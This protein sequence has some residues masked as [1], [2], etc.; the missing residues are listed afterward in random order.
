M[1]VERPHA[2]RPSSDLVWDGGLHATAF[3][4]DGA[5]LTAGADVGWTPELLMATAAGT[6]LMTLVLRLASEAGIEILGY[7]S[8]QRLQ[9]PSENS[10]PA[11]LVSPCISVRS[12]PAADVI[13]SLVA[14]AI[15]MARESGTL[16]RHLRVEPHVAV[17]P[18]SGARW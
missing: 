1:T 16:A 9:G 13:S 8:E 6:A 2:N 18:T 12:Q 5:P 10:C 4:D 3:V 11:V 17:V 7:V 15:E 14:D